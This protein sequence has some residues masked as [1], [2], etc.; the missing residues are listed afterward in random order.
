MSTKGYI[1]LLKLGDTNNRIIY[2]VEKS[3]NVYK[4]KK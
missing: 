1:Y 3:I 2:K 4:K